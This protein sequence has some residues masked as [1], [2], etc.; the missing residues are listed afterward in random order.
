MDELKP[1]P[2]C[3]ASEPD[4]E[5]EEKFG[6]IYRK[7]VC[8][9]CGSSSNGY[10]DEKRAIKAWDRRADDARTRKTMPTYGNG[11]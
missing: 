6:I 1:C 7:V 11:A 5:T 3:G 10:L 9:A 2:F 4:I 8:W